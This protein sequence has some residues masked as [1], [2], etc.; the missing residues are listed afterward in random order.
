MLQILGGGW[1]DT[2]SI[3][4]KVLDAAN[5]LIFLVHSL[6]NWIR[7]KALICKSYFHL[8]PFCHHVASPFR[9]PCYCLLLLLK[10]SGN[11]HQSRKP[12]KKPSIIIRSGIARPWVNSNH[13]AA[14]FAHLTDLKHN[15]TPVKF[16]LLWKLPFPILKI[17]RLPVPCFKDS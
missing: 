11:W 3:L 15:N 9:L 13:V 16:E 2:C 6:A 5:N 10:C 7:D 14:S 1:V 17:P 8:Q 12:G 4:P